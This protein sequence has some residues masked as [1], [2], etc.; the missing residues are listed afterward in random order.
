L[1]E[2]IFFHLTMPRYFLKVLPRPG[3]VTESKTDFKEMKNYIVVLKSRVSREKGAEVSTVVSCSNSAYFNL[4]T[5]TQFGTHASL[6]VNL[7]PCP[8]VR[9][10]ELF[11]RGKSLWL[12]WE[13][14]A[15]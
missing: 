4:I 9:D 13:M 6:S 5:Y 11:L 10:T 8:N 2:A 3:A 1:E 14:N 7:L 15:A 12:A